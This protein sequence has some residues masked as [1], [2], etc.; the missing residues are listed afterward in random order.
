M[1][2]HVSNVGDLAILFQEK[3]EDIAGDSYFW[4][5]QS[6]KA[7]DENQKDATHSSDA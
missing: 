4:F 3:E 2:H 1:K 7:F 5:T 6:Q